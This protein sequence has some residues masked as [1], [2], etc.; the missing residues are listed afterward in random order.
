M[1]TTSPTR[2]FAIFAVSVLV[3]IGDREDSE[4]LALRLLLGSL[5]IL[6]LDSYFLV[7]IFV[8]GVC[9]RVCLR[10]THSE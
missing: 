4:C 5:F 7:A 3:V 10:M 9:M 1:V 6:P 8:Y 2:V